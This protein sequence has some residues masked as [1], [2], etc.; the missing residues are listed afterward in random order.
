MTHACAV[1]TPPVPAPANSHL[2]T[3]LHMNYYFHNVGAAPARVT[4]GAQRVGRGAD[5]ACIVSNRAGGTSTQLINNG[6]T[7]AWIYCDWWVYD[8][9]ITTSQQLRIHKRTGSHLQ[10]SDLRWRGPFPLESGGFHIVTA[11]WQWLVNHSVKKTLIGNI[12]R[13]YW[14][15]NVF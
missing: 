10:V 4:L 8:M 11:V 7:T 5:P 9:Q 6:A 1:Y 2:H 14:Q 15:L 13:Q 3:Y 12:I